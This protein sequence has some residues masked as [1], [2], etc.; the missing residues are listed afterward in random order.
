MREKRESFATG[1]NSAMFRRRIQAPTL[2]WM[3]A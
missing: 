2:E 3:T 1:A